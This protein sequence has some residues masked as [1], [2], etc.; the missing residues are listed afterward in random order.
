VS[1]TQGTIVYDPNQGVFWLA[2]A[3]LA[4]N[5]AMRANLGVAGISPNGSMNFVTAQKWVAAL[6]A[7]GNGSGYM[8][9]NNWQLP[10]APLVDRTCADTGTN[11]GSF[12]PQCTASALGNLYSV[13]LKQTFPASVAAGFAAAVAPFVNMKASY[14][15][16]LQNNGG[17][18]GTSNGGQET[19]SFANGIQGGT[20]INDTY[21]YVLPMVTSAIGAPPSCPAGSAAVIPYTSGPASG[22]AVYDCNTG[23]TWLIN[24]NLAASNTPA[25]LSRQWL[26]RNRLAC[27]SCWAD[28]V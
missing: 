20:T 19:F 16:A 6:N 18:S 1:S 22:K 17:T 24:A 21:Y 7:Y 14:Y 3:N 15:W 9:H 27:S 11:G 2:D 5:S 23:Y 13:G 26:C 8:G 10:V 12:G 28:L 4:G 25:A